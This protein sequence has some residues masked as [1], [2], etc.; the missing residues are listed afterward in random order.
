VL[1]QALDNVGRG[2]MCLETVV[3]KCVASISSVGTSPTRCARKPN[4]GQKYIA[5]S[6]FYKFIKSVTQKTIK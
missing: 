4:K 6:Q 5:E 1:E 3:N 2:G